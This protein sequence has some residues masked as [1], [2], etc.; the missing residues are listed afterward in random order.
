MLRWA[1]PGELGGARPVGWGS[2]L[3]KV[4]RTG[5]REGLFGKWAGWGYGLRRYDP[6]SRGSSQCNLNLAVFLRASNK[7]L[8]RGDHGPGT[9]S[10][11][12]SPEERISRS[13]EEPIVPARLRPCAR[14]RNRTQKRMDPPHEIQERGA[15]PTVIE[16][17]YQESGILSS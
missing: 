15:A 8:R 4:T 12:V 11:Y 10:L 7:V 9:P 5:R 1:N 13:P 6:V 2:H 14:A 3:R 16:R 17:G